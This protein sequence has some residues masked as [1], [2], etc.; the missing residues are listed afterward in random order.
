MKAILLEGE[1]AV[2]KGKTTFS[3]QSRGPGAVATVFRALVGNKFNFSKSS[4]KVKKI[5]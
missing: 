3:H 5:N 1:R 4:W 2:D